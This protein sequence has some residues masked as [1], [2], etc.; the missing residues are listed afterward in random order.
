[1]ADAGKPTNRLICFRLFEVQIRISVSVYD[2]GFVAF[3][4]IYQL[5]LL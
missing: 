3:I 5:L 1:M 2:C 4:N